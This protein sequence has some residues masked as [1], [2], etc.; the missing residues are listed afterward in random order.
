[1]TPTEWIAEKLRA[2]R[3]RNGSLVP[4]IPVPGR[5]CL[6]GRRTPDEGCADA[7][8]DSVRLSELAPGQPGVVTCLEEPSSAA[9]RKLAA[10]GILPGATV[11][12][13]QRYPVWI[14]RTG[15]AE[16]ALDR[17]MVDRIRVRTDEG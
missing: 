4:G 1:M 6:E 16:L 14:L 17:E 3:V 10:M 9:S 5:D 11:E 13:R 12:P 2:W 7:S 8:C 15:R